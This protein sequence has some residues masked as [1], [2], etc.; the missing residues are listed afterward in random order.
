MVYKRHND[1]YKMFEGKLSSA[2]IGAQPIVL[3]CGG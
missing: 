3:Q 1:D 2:Q